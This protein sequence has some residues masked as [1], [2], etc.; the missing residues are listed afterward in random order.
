MGVCFGV[1]WV[2]LSI[3][4]V[5]SIMGRVGVMVRRHGVARTISDK[6]DKAGTFPRSRLL[7]AHQLVTKRSA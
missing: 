5:M 6:R 4:G 1:V 7:L 3:L 2:V